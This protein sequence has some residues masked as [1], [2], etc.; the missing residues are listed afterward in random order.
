[1]K[2]PLNVISG[3]VLLGLCAIGAMST[4]SL[5]PPIQTDAVGPAYLPTASLA[6]VAFCSVLLIIFGLRNPPVKDLWGDRKASAKVLLF[7]VFYLFF[8]VSMCYLGRF[9]YSLENP[10][11]SHSVGFAVSN[12][13]FLY[14]ACRYLGRTNKLE[15]LLIS[16]GSTALLVLGLSVFFKVFL[17]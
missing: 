6:L 8:L 4:A 13:I 1:M 14:A 7:Y 16:V 10:P 9:V 3:A 5:P 2:N 15:L 11:F 12:I 17:P